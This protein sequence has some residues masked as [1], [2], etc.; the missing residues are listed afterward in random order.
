VAADAASEAYRLAL[1]ALGLL[2]GRRVQERTLGL[3]ARR[4]DAIFER[5]AILPGEEPFGQADGGVVPRQP[6]VDGPRRQVELAH[7]AERVERGVPARQREL[8]V[9]AVEAAAVAPHALDDVGETAIA[10]RQDALDVAEAGLVILERDALALRLLAQ[11]ALLAQHVVDRVHRA[12][13][14]RRVR[15]GHV[16]ADR[17]GDVGV[18]ANLASEALQAPA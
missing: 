16:R 1:P 11:H 5:A 13:L 4:A 9:P 10:A 3:A 6:R 14:E 7:H 12:P 15:L 17:D 18:V 8:L 2:D